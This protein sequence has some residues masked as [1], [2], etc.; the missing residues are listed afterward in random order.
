MSLNSSV[1]KVPRK[2]AMPPI[3]G[4]GS[5]CCFLRQGLSVK[6]IFRAHGYKTR[7]KIIVADKDVKN[8]FKSINMILGSMMKCL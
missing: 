2:I 3:G 4:I 8:R 5:L 6:P 7:I 1:I